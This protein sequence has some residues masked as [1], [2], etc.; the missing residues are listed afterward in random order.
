[1][2]TIISNAEEDIMSKTGTFFVLHKEHDGWK[3]NLLYPPILLSKI[4]L[5]EESYL[6]LGCSYW[7]VI[8][9]SSFL[10]CSGKTTWCCSLL[11]YCRTSLSQINRFLCFLISYCS[12][13]AYLF[14]RLLVSIS[15]S[16]TLH[17]QYLPLLVCSQLWSTFLM[18][19][20]LPGY[21]CWDALSKLKGFHVL[22]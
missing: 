9:G 16:G 6:I 13:L 15:Y 3:F 7:Y 1:M 10:R 4:Y 20:S 11:F 18:L 22:L 17:T 2:I 8:L 5:N 19:L 12:S 14:L 21:W